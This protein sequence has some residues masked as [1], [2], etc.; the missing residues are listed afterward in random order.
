MPW[1]SANAGAERFVKCSEMAVVQVSN[2]CPAQSLRMA[3]VKEGE[4][5][6]EVAGMFAGQDMRPS[7]QYNISGAD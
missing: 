6:M 5:I 2:R 4:Y 7:Q 1:P 3:T